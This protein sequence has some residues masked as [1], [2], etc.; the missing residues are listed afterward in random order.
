M[1]A[2]AATNPTAGEPT[3][4]EPQAEY[5]PEPRWQAAAMVRKGGAR[6][7]N[8]GK[9]GRSGNVREGKVKNPGST[10]TGSCPNRSY[11]CWEGIRLAKAKRSTNAKTQPNQNATHKYFLA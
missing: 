2:A 9:K 7:Q 10:I 1:P 5:P 4:R 3:N 6:V 11:K 8:R